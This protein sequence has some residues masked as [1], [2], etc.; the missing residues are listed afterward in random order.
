[1]VAG[2]ARAQ[3]PGA[4]TSSGC[5]RLLQG[6]GHFTMKSFVFGAVTAFVLIL[7]AIPQYFN[8]DQVVFE[9]KQWFDELHPVMNSIEKNIVKNASLMDA[10]MGVEKNIFSRPEQKRPD[11]FEI[12][13]LGEIILQGGSRGQLLILI[14][15]FEEGKV[16][17]RCFAN[18]RR[19]VSRVC[20]KNAGKTASP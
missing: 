4:G 13:R 16:R 11:V 12:T 19:I 20:E 10:D 3:L 5:W 2:D 7:I 18:P 8:D 6:G 14:P 9:A 17:W 15:A 1:M